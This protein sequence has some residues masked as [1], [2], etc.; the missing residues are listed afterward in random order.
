MQRLEVR[1][2]Q[3]SNGK[4]AFEYIARALSLNRPF[5]VLRV[6][7]AF[8]RWLKY[9]TQSSSSKSKTENYQGAFAGVASKLLLKLLVLRVLY[10]LMRL[11]PSGLLSP[12]E[13]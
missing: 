9:E 3:P 11:A 7:R 13:T 12:G 6:E 8:N 2:S 5:E 1:H 4:A 10:L